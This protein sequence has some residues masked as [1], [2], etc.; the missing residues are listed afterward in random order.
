M[1]DEKA[2][3]VDWFA[4]E[5]AERGPVEGFE[6][7]MFMVKMGGTIGWTGDSRLMV[8]ATPGWCDCEGIAVQATEMNGDIVRKG[9]EDIHLD[10]HRLTVDQYIES[11][12]PLLVKAK[13][14]YPRTTPTK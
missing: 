8:F 7:E 4:K 3:E 12:R 11:I 9:F 10:L 5:V 14:E 6:I 2:F 1:A 13:T